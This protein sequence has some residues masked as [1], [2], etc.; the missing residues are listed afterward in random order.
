MNAYPKYK[1]TGI[2]WIG[3]IP[4][5][6]TV[7]RA[8]YYTEIK[9]GDAIS[10]E[11]IN[12]NGM[13]PVYGGGELIGYTDEYNIDG[14]TIVIGRVGARCGCITLTSKKSWATDN[15]LIVDTT[16]DVQYFAKLLDAANLNRLNESN[17]QPLITATKIKNLS[18][19][20]PPL[21]EQQEIATYLDKK[22]AKIDELMAEKTNQVE[23]LQSYRTSVITEAVTR[24]LNPNAPLRQSGIDWI[25]EI[26]EHWK[27]LKLKFGLSE[28][29]DGTHFSPET[30]ENGYSY[31]TATD[32]RGIGIDYAS[33]KKVSDDDYLKLV[34][35]GCEILKNDVLLVKDGATTGRVGMKIDDTPAVTLSSV[36]MLRTKSHSRHKFLYYILQSDIIQS[37]ISVAMAGA[38]MPRITLE[39]LG[40]FL[41]LF[42]PFNEQQEIAAYLD[43]KTAKIDKLISELNTQ[44]AELADYKQAVIS[45]AVTG[46]VDVRN[47]RI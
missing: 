20:V 38:A 27:I 12:N 33:T 39:K 25:G 32:V 14:N 7:S 9:S 13:F 2:D 15:A 6:W 31:V 16:F 5:G 43:E 42:P 8:K 28:I 36:A 34:Q 1:D 41:S 18:V 22:T 3:K 26:P 30:V 17:A 47:Y 4:E 44:L 11:Q 40:N 23:D 45:E 37:Q 19:P 24:G 21:S 35:S 10:K 46:K 29:K